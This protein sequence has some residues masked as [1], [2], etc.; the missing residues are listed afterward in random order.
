MQDDSMGQERTHSRVL[1]E[2]STDQ[3][4][5]HKEAQPNKTFAQVDCNNHVAGEYYGCNTIEDS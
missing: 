5:Q 1:K 3:A 4:L 2:I